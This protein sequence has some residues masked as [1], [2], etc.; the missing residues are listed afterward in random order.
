MVS[1][2]KNK[3]IRRIYTK[4]TVKIENKKNNCR[5]YN[6]IGPLQKDGG[7]GCFITVFHV[8]LLRSKCLI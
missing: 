5:E 8:N 4:K 2:V 6:L 7:T 1:F 3:Q